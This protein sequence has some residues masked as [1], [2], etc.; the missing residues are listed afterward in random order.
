[1]LHGSMRGPFGRSRGLAGGAFEAA[2]WAAAVV[3][4]GGTVS[5]GRLAIVATFVTA[6]KAAGTWAATDDYWP[7]WGENAAQALTSL[8]QKRLATAVN[9]PTFTADRGYVFNGTTN[10]IN[11]NFVPSTNG[12]AMTGT[13]VRLA[14]YERTNVTDANIAFGA[15]SGANWLVLY[16]RLGAQTFTGTNSDNNTAFDLPSSDSRGYTSGS[17][18]GTTLANLAAYKNGLALNRTGVVNVVSG[19]GV[20]PL[21][22]GANNNGGTAVNLRPCSVGFAAIGASLTAAQELAQ[23]NNVQAWAT[24][25][26]ANV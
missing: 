17:V 23:Y 11:V 7:L 16:P 18:N 10:Y 9:T 1:M 5:A 13:S 26:G 20:Q 14:V 15:I 4:N 24:A 25:L 22:I 8:K 12:I 6:E 2:S 19:L 3:A 21:L